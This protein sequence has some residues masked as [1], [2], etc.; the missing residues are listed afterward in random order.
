MS[1][2]KRS[3]ME[4]SMPCIY[5]H[6]SFGKKVADKLPKELQSIIKQHPHQ[7]QIGL[8]GPDFLFF[9]RP[10]FKLRTNQ[11][12]YW[13]HG[14]T[15][16]DF[17]HALLPSLRKKKSVDTGTFAYLLGYICH[18]ALD[19]ECHSFVIPLS[20]KPGYNHLVIENEFDRYLLKKD[21]FIPTKYPIWRKI[22]TSP[23]VIASI[24]EAYRPLHLS[25]KKIRKALRSMRFFKRMLTCGCSLKRA[26]IRGCMKVS[27][28]YSE[29]EGHM[30]NLHPKKYA[31]KTNQS[32]QCL[33]DNSISL[34]CELI[35]NFHQSVVAGKDL[36]PRFS[37]TFKDNS[38]HVS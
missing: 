9:Y 4:V 33:Y 18:F 37:T 29:L 17:L 23:S 7:F 6:D 24:Y 14:Q 35:Q 26:L 36:H 1:F 27:M 16:H 31:A 22:P 11:M 30:M 34:A 38:L 28:H 32:M 10:L 3:G 21:G 13:Q 19:S 20:E 2:R 25:K 8:Q 12:G 15:M 5:A